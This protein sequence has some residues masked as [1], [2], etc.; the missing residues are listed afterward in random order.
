MSKNRKTRQ[1]CKKAHNNYEY[2]RLF[3][4]ELVYC[5]ICGPNKGCNRQAKWTGDQNC[6][7]S[8]RKTQ[9]KGVCDE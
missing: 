7:K 1:S 6:W 4:E 2:V 8:H 3:R 5:P 9:W